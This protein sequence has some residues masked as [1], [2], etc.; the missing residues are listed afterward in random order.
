M[1]NGFVESLN[2]RLRDE[3]L[4]EHVFRGLPADGTSSKTEGSTTTTTGRIPAPAAS[5]RTHSQP[6]PA[7]TTTRTTRTESGYKRGQ[8]RRTVTRHQRLP[9]SCI[10]PVKACVTTEIGV[11]ASCE[12]NMP[13]RR[14]RRVT[15][16]VRTALV[17]TGDIIPIFTMCQIGIVSI[18]FSR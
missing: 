13:R 2:G 11:A 18:I 7:G 8:R 1:Q 9:R 4:N 5:F 15:R 17:R 10:G 3:C 6:G 16:Q 12:T 14:R